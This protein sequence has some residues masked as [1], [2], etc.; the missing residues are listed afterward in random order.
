MTTTPGRT[1]LFLALVLLILAMGFPA[2]AQTP[3]ELRVTAEVANIRQM[4]D[5]GSVIVLQVPRDTT[6]TAVSREGDWYL[7]SV[8]AEDGRTVRGYVHVSLVTPVETPPATE[9]KPETNPPPQPKPRPTVPPRTARPAASPVSISASEARFGLMI[10]GGGGY[11]LGGDLNSSAQGQADYFGSVLGVTGSPAVSPAHLGYVFGGELLV[12]LADRIS[13]G[14]GLDYLES[15]RESIVL[16]QKGNKNYS[17]LTRPAM[18]ALPIR[19]FVAYSPLKAFYVKLGLEY[20]FAG[21]SYYFRTESG[22]Y[23]RE[24][25]G[26]ATGQGLGAVA[27]FGLEWNI[28]SSLAFVIEATGHYAPL[29]GFKGTGTVTDELGVDEEESGK[30]DYFELKNLGSPFFPDLAV[31]NKLPTEAGVYNPRDA[32]I[33]FTGFTLKAGLKIRF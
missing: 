23:W 15:R 7:V 22:S 4:P 29:A 17:Y 2:A 5:I 32:E 8:V 13:L 11:H 12:P 9:P 31:R 10:L 30:L 20:Y 3:A 18:H 33:D 26:T 28:V 24:S 19:V 14:F 1:A 25:S 16:Y 27:G 21:L 6:L